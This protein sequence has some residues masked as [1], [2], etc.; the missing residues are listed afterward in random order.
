MIC[1]KCNEENKEGSSF[2]CRC[3]TAFGEHPKKSIEKPARTQQPPNIRTE[4]NIKSI[5]YI[6]FAIF[7]I[8]LN[9]NAYDEYTNDFIFFMLLAGGAVMLLI[10][11]ASLTNKFYDI[12]CPYCGKTITVEDGAQGVDCAVCG[13]RIIIE[14]YTPK[15]K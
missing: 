2:C 7:Y 15:K 9:V 14:N 4:F 10:G 12:E 11:L 1:P 3:G 8:V 5:I 6:G 13:E